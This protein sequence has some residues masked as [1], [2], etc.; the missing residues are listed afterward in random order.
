M[1]LVDFN[2]V[3]MSSMHASYAKGL[4][5]GFD[6]EIIRHMILNMLR[7]NNA[8]FRDKYGE[9]IIAC[10]SPK[11]WR[12]S[13]FSFYKAHRK[14][15]RDKLTHIEWPKVFELFDNVKREL[16]EYTRYPV[17]EVEGAEGDDVIATLA[18]KY[19]DQPNIIIS[20]DKDFGQ[21]QAYTNTDQYDPIRD[22]HIKIDNPYEFLEEHIIRGDRNDG[23]PNIL[24]DD[25]VFIQ[26][27]KRQG[28]V[29]ESRLETWKSSPVDQ[30]PNETHR[31]NWKRNQ[32]LID[33]RAIPA[34][35]QNL[36]VEEFEAQR[37]MNKTH[38]MLDYVKKYKLT[39]LLDV[40]DQF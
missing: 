21:L 11:S 22:R 20:A 34:S 27:N 12:K 31:R 39:G 28:K 26:P 3:M 7:G 5:A 6:G 1:I 23:V 14:G 15:E 36:I 32:I 16:A 8:R 2:Q 19:Q 18:I 30:W 10:D 37:N 25:D 9:L 33:L 4:S 29:T 24:S 17:I 40:I 35:I 13:V 38:R